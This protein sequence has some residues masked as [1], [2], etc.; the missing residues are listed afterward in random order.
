MTRPNIACSVSVVS[1]LMSSLTVDHWAT[2]EQILCY[3]KVAPGRGILYKDHGHTRVECFTDAD[4][5][6]SRE[7]EINF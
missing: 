5:A 6:E 1:P 2:V 3:L 7:N 4:W